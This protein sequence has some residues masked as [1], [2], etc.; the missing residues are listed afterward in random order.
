MSHT[1]NNIATIDIGSKDIKCIVAHKDDNNKINI[2][3][4]GIV[5]SKGV[6]GGVIQDPNLVKNSIKEA[7]AKAQSDSGVRYIEQYVVGINSVHLKCFKSSASMRI[8]NSTP[9]AEDIR[10]LLEMSAAKLTLVKEYKIVQV[11][12]IF[13]K[14]DGEYYV[15]DPLNKACTTLEASV[16]VI[17]IKDEYLNLFNKSLDFLDANKLSYVSSAYA[18]MLGVV[19]IEQYNKGANVVVD[20]GHD[21]SQIVISKKDTIV[22]VDHIPFGSNNIAKDLSITFKTP[23]L[24]ANMLKEE[25]GTLLP[26]GEEISKI[27][28]PLIGN[29][30]QHREVSLEMIMP[31]IHARVEEILYLIKSNLTHSGF[32]EFMHHG[33]LFLTGGMSNTVGIYELSNKIFT[34]LKV[35]NNDTRIIN[36]SP[37][38][39]TAKS[40]SV[41]VGL[42]LSQL[43]D[44]LI[45]QL[46]SHGK[47]ID[48]LNNYSAP[49]SIPAS[50]AAPS[51]ASNPAVQSDGV[52][53]IDVNRE[54]ELKDIQ[55]DFER[56]KSQKPKSNGLLKKLGEYL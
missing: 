21:I 51:V 42:V 6:S 37:V 31:I 43:D 56:Q 49:N 32:S 25:Y 3:G 19:D 29:E 34:D 36:E 26:L 2:I 30:T 45:T 24:A 12:P 10:S 18:S 11:I 47:L 15:Q 20:I 40:L 53:R 28:L 16:Y 38:N 46:N 13:F 41:C 7:I 39:T 8:Q 52:E 23:T 33:N 44:S 50:Y 22:Y 54:L 4:K 27:K 55:Q 5:A 9:S 17:S 35:K 14:I 48:T 1:K